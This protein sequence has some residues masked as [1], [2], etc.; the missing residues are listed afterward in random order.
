[1]RSV[2]PASI[3]KQL[4]IFLFFLGKSGLHRIIESVETSEVESDVVEVS[5]PGQ[6]GIHNF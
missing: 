6:K 5:R 4:F 3:I 2:G 1:M